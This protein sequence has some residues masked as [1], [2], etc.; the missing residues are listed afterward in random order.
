MEWRAKWPVGSLET[1]AKLRASNVFLPPHPLSSRL[2][3][4]PG[5]GWGAAFGG[6]VVLPVA[7]I[8]QRQ[9]PYGWT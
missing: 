7:G 5:P 4:G 1:I 9:T 3:A 8:L 6:M 2:G